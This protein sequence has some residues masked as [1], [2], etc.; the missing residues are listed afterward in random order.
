[1]RRHAVLFLPL[2]LACILV[3]C[4]TYDANRVARWTSRFDD[5]PPGPITPDQLLGETH[6]K[7]DLIP[8]GTVGRR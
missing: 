3:A 8:S 1:M 2:A 7:L 5:G 6:V 4:V